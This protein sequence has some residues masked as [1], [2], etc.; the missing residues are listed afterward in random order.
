MTEAAPGG[1]AELSTSTTDGTGASTLN[2]A[3]EAG[4]I[5]ILV[6]SSSGITAGEHI[7]IDSGVNEIELRTVEM[8]DG[9][10]LILNAPTG[11]YH[12][13]GVAVQ[14][15][16]AVT[17]T[18]GDVIIDQIPGIYE[19]V[20]LPDP[21]MDIQPAY[22]LGTNSKR[23]FNRVYAGQQTYS[24]SV[25]NI[26]LLNG[27][28]L[29]YPIGR[30]VSNVSSVA[31]RT[32]LSTSAKKGDMYITVAGVSGLALGD[33]IG[34]DVPV[35]VSSNAITSTS[36][37]EFRKIAS[38]PSSS[39]TL[40]LDYPLQYDHTSAGSGTIQITEAG[41][42]VYTH[43]ILETSDLPTMTWHAH[44]RSSD[45]TEATT[46]DFDRRYFGGKLGSATIA[47]EEGGMVTM[48]WDDV[49]FLG[50]VHN[51]KQSSA[52]VPFYTL[53]QP[54]RSTEVVQ[55]TTEPYY[56]SSG[57][58]S[59][60]GTTVA[61][62]R[63]FSLSINNNL[64]SRYYLTRRG[65]SRRRGPSEIRENRR[66]YSM[67]ATLALPD[68]QNQ[69]T[70]TART[71]FNELL[72]E[73]D[74]GSGRSGFDIS[75]VFTRGDNDSITISIPDDGTSNVGADTQGA[76]IKSA[77]HNITTDGPLQVD[78][79]ILFR[80]MKITVVDAEYYYP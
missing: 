79:D 71:L 13:A 18:A 70:A 65:N 80:N 24:G 17:D 21:T 29:R 26:V 8:V 47:A 20:D 44:M 59:M 42:S 22:F 31:T 69:T 77:P 2:G 5:S 56:F 46:H 66:E 15:V 7:D 53:M 60:F 33:I 54:I 57:T 74:Y 78:A 62:L 32:Y 40:L 25:S 37:G 11:F 16:T 61:R 6:A 49:S 3:H 73:G 72:F 41:S 55:P 58:I 27:K 34:I 43:T 28:P 14:V 51:Q 12:A 68:T 64:E 63:S 48:S 19:T 38:D 4:S 75:L 67:S 36:T 30:V 76:F 50:M 45:E 39:A 9:N 10:S 35:A 1:Y 52:G 23:N